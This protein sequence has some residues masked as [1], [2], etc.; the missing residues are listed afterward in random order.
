[1]FE[2]DLPKKI[3]EQK[4]NVQ[5]LNKTNSFLYS[6]MLSNFICKNNVKC[7]IDKMLFYFR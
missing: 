6:L 1:M 4:K 2:A 7:D 3:L 5:T